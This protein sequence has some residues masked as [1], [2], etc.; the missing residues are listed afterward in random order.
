MA[1]D[2]DVEVTIG[3]TL[4][5][6]E[7]TLAGAREAVEGFTGQLEALSGIGRSISGL[8][9]A[10]AAA[11]AVEGIRRFIESMAELGLSTERASEVLGVPTE[12]IGGLSLAAEA[13]GLSIDSLEMAFTRLSRNVVDQ[14]A[15]AKRALDAL[16]LTFSDLAGKNATQ[17]FDVLAG[18]FSRIQDGATKDAI[19][20]EL[21]GRGFYNLLPLI[22]QGAG[23]MAQWQEAADRAGTSLSSNTVQA[24]EETHAK[25][26]ELGA[27]FQGLGV[28]AFNE[29]GAAIR[30]AIDILTGWVEG[31]TSAI[32]SAGSL[33]D[34]IDL[35]AQSFQLVES[36]AVVAQNAIHTLVVAGG[37]GVTV[38]IEGFE[39]LGHVVADIFAALAGGIEGFFS[40]LVTAG[41]EAT[42]A[43]AKQF[44]DLG[45]VISSALHG[46]F[47]GAKAAF[48]QTFTDIAASNAAIRGAFSKAG[49]SFDFSKVEQDYAQGASNIR[50]IQSDAS[51][52]ITDSNAQTVA[53]LDYIW[54]AGDEKIENTE[55][56]HQAKMAAAGGGKGGKGG[57]ADKAQLTDLEAEIDAYKAQAKQKETILAEELKTHQISMKQWLQQSRD[58]L[59]DERQDMQDAYSREL[60]IAGLTSA[61]IA[62]IKK[63]EQ[64]ALAQIDQQELQDQM[65]AAE[66]TQK[67]WQE[68]ASTIENAFNSQ[69]HGLLS[70][71]TSWSQAM[72]NIALDLAEDFIKAIEKMVV[73]WIMGIAQMKTASAALSLGGGAGG[74]FGSLLGGLGGLIGLS[75]GAWEIPG[76]MPALL[77]AGEMV[78]PAGPASAMRESMG[79]GQS[80]TGAPS[81]SASVRD[82]HMH[83]H[84]P[85]SA[86][87]AQT[88]MANNGALV[89]AVRQAVRHGAHLGLR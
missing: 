62:N 40:G 8:G 21:F 82:V 77:H 75:S 89:K 36:G 81:R 10:F 55:K 33:R 72:K 16:G 3:A 15:S 86:T 80:P 66:A 61:Q 51:K 43:V 69:L 39:T 31:I 88:L 6:L 41:K 27:A 19:G 35:L 24:M 5:G 7:G 83:L 29:F 48:G 57:G 79:G 52:A 71:T 20:V 42:M 68:A 14:S 53:Q 73:Q 18:A 47:A 4:Q 45:S 28:A 37:S 58:A 74:L 9:E 2:S 17:Q 84:Q 44:E 11:F 49:G 23:A 50:K 54:R 1:G 13:S 85:D 87:M 46:D 63:Q 32:N 60:A 26:T 30:G 64:Q 78:V 56:Q 67:Q 34:I 12:Q 70:G 65:K 25:L 38:L 76:T 22:N 59:E